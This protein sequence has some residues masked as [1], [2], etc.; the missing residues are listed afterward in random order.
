M[1]ENY[2]Y[3]Y[4]R[5]KPFLFKLIGIIVALFAILRLRNSPVFSFLLAIGSTSIFVYQTGIEIDFKNKKYRYI[6]TFGPQIF[7]QWL[8]LPKMEYISVFKT[9]IISSATGMSNT[10]ITHT[11]EVIQV[12]LVVSNNK[13]LRMLELKDI[14]E[15][16]D[17]AKHYAKELELS[18]Y[19]ATVRPAK[20]LD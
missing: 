6:T 18:I 8:D 1:S 10:S 7:G 14:K 15:A 5:D 2:K 17:F 4:K 19:D 11:D 12:N 3:I 9:N 13:T 20:W 16:F